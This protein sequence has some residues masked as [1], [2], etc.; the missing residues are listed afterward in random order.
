M[1]GN[2]PNADLTW[3]ANIIKS[4]LSKS[5]I[6]I[7]EGR[8]SDYDDFVTTILPSPKEIA[9]F[10]KTEIYFPP[11]EWLCDTSRLHLHNDCLPDTASVAIGD[12]VQT[13]TAIDYESSQMLDSYFRFLWVARTEMSE[14]WFPTGPEVPFSVCQ[15]YSR[16][17]GGIIYFRE[18]VTVDPCTAKIYPGECDESY[19][20]EFDE[21]SGSDNEDEYKHTDLGKSSF[22]ALFVINAWSTRD[23]FWNI[24]AEADETK[25][26]FGA[27]LKQ[28]RDLCAELGL[29]KETRSFEI[30]GVL[31]KIEPPAPKRLSSCKT[32]PCYG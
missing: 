23:D 5:I 18:F 1:P 16:L 7:H 31:C 27:E 24:V 29:S 6:A 9:R 26:V 14:G 17:E 2:S 15:G 13:D 19:F 22:T 3:T 25:I 8:H 10:K 20:G 4:Y 28:V 21:F 32:Y 12:C 11:P 30:D